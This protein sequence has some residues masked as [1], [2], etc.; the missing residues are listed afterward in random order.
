MLFL[1]GRHSYPITREIALAA[2]DAGFDGLVYPSYF[3]LIRTGAMPFETALGISHRRIPQLREREKSKTILNL[4]IFGRPI[5]LG[6]VIV[7]CIN[8]VIIT[9]IVYDGHFGP[10]GHLATS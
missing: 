1:A 9:R 4:A 10:V 8:R 6:I 7:R 2:R 5:E 3:G